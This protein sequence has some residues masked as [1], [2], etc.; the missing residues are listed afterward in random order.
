MFHS[1]NQSKQDL[2]VG[3][4]RAS[5]VAEARL[6]QLEQAK[7][8][9]LQWLRSRADQAL[10]EAEDRHRRELQQLARE[11]EAERTRSNAERYRC[12]NLQAS[13]SQLR[14]EQ[15]R[16]PQGEAEVRRLRETTRHLRQQLEASEAE[17]RAARRQLDEALSSQRHRQSPSS[18]R[19]HSLGEE[20]PIEQ[21]AGSWH[22]TSDSQWQQTTAE[23]PQYSSNGVCNFS[24]P[25]QKFN[26]IA[27]KAPPGQEF[28]SEG[29]QFGDAFARQ[30]PFGDPLGAHPFGDFPENKPDHTFPPSF[31]STPQWGSPTEDF[32]PSSVEK[33]SSRRKHKEKKHRSQ[34]GSEYA[35]QDQLQQPPPSGFDR[36][37]SPAAPPTAGPEYAEAIAS[38]KAMGFAEDRL[39]V[40][41]EA[42]G[43]DVGKAVP[44]LLSEM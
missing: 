17:L 39:A 23:A 4:Q 26:N 19:R 22:E 10:Q 20:D 14:Q 43:G 11:L 44:V 30:Q 6:A 9:E 40:V 34:T 15:P 35:W 24:G 1:M 27:P 7:N 21:T 25:D 18:R 28:R 37:E 8:R 41:L 38:L 33:P 3:L 29:P 36:G 12:E 16:V 42:V 32:Q 2:Q 13:L 5:A 31:A